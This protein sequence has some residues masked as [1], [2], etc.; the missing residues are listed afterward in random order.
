MDSLLEPDLAPHY[1]AW[2]ADPSPDR[3][4]TLL[5]ALEPTIRGA[6]KTHVGDPNPLL[7][8]RARRMTLEGLRSYDPA[9]GR[10]QNHLY[11][12]LQGLKRVAR[13]QSQ[14]V[15]VPERIALERYHLEDATRQMQDELGRE[16]TDDELGD[17]TGLSPR[18]MA[19][20]RRY[21]PAVA[22][23]SLE[24]RETGGGF[25]GGVRKPGGESRWG[26]IVYHE[27]DPYHKAVMEHTL[28]M[29]GRPA[30]PNHEIARKLNRSPGAISQAK[31][32]IQRMLDEEHELS[33]FG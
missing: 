27:L 6:I 21:N 13:K 30:L 20:L 31:L 8:S 10:L 2:K 7:V 3:A 5:D 22:E 11:N 24:D 19:T 4:A 14:I 33:P 16:P 15:A 17:R 26:E 28:G 32:R 23:G 9:R 29:N 12:H 18:R 1:H 25:L